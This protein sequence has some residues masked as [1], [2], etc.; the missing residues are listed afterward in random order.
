MPDENE[1]RTAVR[2][3]VSDM[4][5]VPVK[6]DD[7]LISSGLIDSLSILKL[8]SRLETRLGVRIPADNLQP[9]DF[10]SVDSIIDIVLRHG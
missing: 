8:M 3:V 5:G 1:L 9:D 7:P 2:A 4:V 10:D 6:D